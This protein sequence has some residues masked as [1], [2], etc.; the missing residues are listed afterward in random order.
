[1]ASNIKYKSVFLNK[2]SNYIEDLFH[3][4]K[5]LSKSIF[6]YIN[7]YFDKNNEILYHNT[8][9]YRLFFSDN[10][11][12]EFI[13]NSLEIKPEEINECLKRIPSIK[14]SW[15]LIN[16]PFNILMI[17]LIRH[18]TIN[19]DKQ[20]V[21]LTLMYLTLSIYSSLHYKS[22][23]YPPN[24]NIMQYT[25][26][27]I[28]NK[29]YFKQYGS[30]FKALY[31]I[32]KGSHDKYTSFLK[33]DDDNKLIQYFV[34][35]RSRLN[36][37]MKSFNKE[38]YKDEKE[39]NYLNSSTDS[40]EPD[41][42]HENENLS[43]M[44]TNLTSKVSISFFSNAVNEK[45]V[46]MSAHIANINGSVLKNTIVDIKNNENKNVVTLI[47]NIFQIYL[48]DEENSI[49]SLG[50]QKFITYCINIYSKSNTKDKLVLEIKTIL[51]IFLSKYCDKYNNTEREMTK[52][53][54]RK[55][56]YV[57]FVILISRVIN[58]SYLKNLITD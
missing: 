31:A 28:S 18:Y 14:S 24:D 20:G 37:Q 30:V 2:F 5:N 22:Y 41:N 35:L 47:K 6:D 33:S 17:L 49:N 23:R 58:A 15:K 9:T 38:F 52:S 4:N 50:S 27:R 42:Y 43:G 26:N 3:N 55:S 1:M 51:D 16:N 53:N 34:N 7:K 44:I 8:P 12:R 11:D 36:N 57:Y 56:V 40:Y 45:F 19:N 46:N 54:Y 32:A 10:P 48:M 25:I 39:G 29:Y 21:D 13:Y